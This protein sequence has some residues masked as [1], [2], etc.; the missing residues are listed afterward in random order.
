MYIQFNDAFPKTWIIFTYEELRRIHRKMSVKIHM[1]GFIATYCVRACV[2]L[3]EYRRKRGIQL[4]YPFSWVF[5]LFFCTHFWTS[6]IFYFYWDR[7]YHFCSWIVDF[8]KKNCDVF[9]MSIKILIFI[10]EFY[11]LLNMKFGCLLF[12]WMWWH[13]KVELRKTT[14]HRHVHTVHTDRERE[15]ER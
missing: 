10:L 7:G 12:E 13:E 3:C 9:N 11:Q 5:I 14:N 4:F 15:E 1:F 8:E 2:R 6:Y